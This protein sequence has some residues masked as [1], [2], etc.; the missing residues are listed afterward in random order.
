MCGRYTIFT[1]AAALEARFDAYVVWSKN[2]C[3]L[4]TRYFR[5]PLRKRAGFARRQSSGGCQPAAT[6]SRLTMTAMT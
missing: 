3:S 5:R 4:T 6:H 1:D 2:L